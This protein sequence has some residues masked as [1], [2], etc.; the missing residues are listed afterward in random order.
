MDILVGGALAA[1]FVVSVQKGL[2]DRPGKSKCNYS[3]TGIDPFVTVPRVAVY[4]EVTTV[5]QRKE[6]PMI[7]QQRPTRKALKLMK[8]AEDCRIQK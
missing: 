7:T 1:G 3:T 8:T 5:P 6:L 2:L 4:Y